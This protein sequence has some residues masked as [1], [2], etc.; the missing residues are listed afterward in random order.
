MAVHLSNPTM[1]PLGVSHKSCDNDG[2]ATATPLNVLNGAMAARQCH[3]EKCSVQTDCLLTTKQQIHVSH[4]NGQKEA[5][6]ISATIGPGSNGG[7][8]SWRDHIK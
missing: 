3:C 2:A 8:T 1:K 6:L 7:N 4:Q 5:A